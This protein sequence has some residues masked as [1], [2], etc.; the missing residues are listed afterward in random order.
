MRC[1]LKFYF[2][3][4]I[5][6][7]CISLSQR[8]LAINYQ[9]GTTD[10]YDGTYLNIALVKA[11]GVIYRN[12]MIAIGKV[13]SVAGGEVFN[14][15]DTYDPITNQLTIP[16]VIVGGTHYPNVVVTVDSV[17]KVGLAFPNGIQPGGLTQFCYKTDCIN[18]LDKFAFTYQI[19]PSNTPIILNQK[20]NLTTA[21]QA[22]VV[23]AN[24]IISSTP[25]NMAIVVIENDEIIFEKY[26]PQ[27]TSQTPLM[28]YSASKSMTS[29]AVGK[30]ICSG[31]IK[32]I[33]A[34][35]KDINPSL[36]AMAYGDATVR[37]LLMMSSGA[38][39]G[40]L[41]KGGTPDISTSG[42]PTLPIF[43]DILQQLDEVKARQV[44]SDG[45]LVMPGEEFSYKNYDNLSLS[46]MFIQNGV[47]HFPN[48]FE[49][50]VWKYF[51]AENPAY[52]VHDKNG[53]VYT[54]STLIATPR[55]WARVG[56]GIKNI[57]KANNNDCFTNYLK[58]AFARD[59]VNDCTILGADYCIS[60]T[61]THY[62]YQYW[63]NGANDLPGTISMNGAYGQRLVI[64]PAK[65]R[66]MWY[67]TYVLPSGVSTPS[68]ALDRMFAAW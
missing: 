40:S 51:G 2:I 20:Q 50:E 4:I 32:D 6:F 60:P 23:K 33:N 31:L 8:V 5:T 13:V 19:Q 62:G 44:R 3:L 37:Q 36:N 68:G 35:S 66:V 46:L 12:V 38:L 56:V 18:N 27:T 47:N 49:N 59:I 55:D 63:V 22:L 10:N 21:Q 30:A 11:N 39:R 61:Y 64:N 67:S 15:V 14:A 29:L 24:S 45:S 17:L 7:L 9:Y 53:I 43:W 16:D 54:N 57:I 52:W 25:G 34:K 42:N 65:N 1:I 28:G 48:V 41:A 58:D 26:H